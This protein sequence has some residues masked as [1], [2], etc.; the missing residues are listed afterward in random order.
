MR[1]FTSFLILPV[2]ALVFLFV[3]FSFV[4]PRAHSLN[5]FGGWKSFS[6]S[7]QF[8][9]VRPNCF[10]ASYFIAPWH[11]RATVDSQTALVDFVMKRR[12]KK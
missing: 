9:E 11:H 4:N 5:S 1:G 10:P 3:Y 2:L 7:P 8:F 6:E 12:E